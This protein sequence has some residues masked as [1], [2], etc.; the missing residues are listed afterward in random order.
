MNTKE[1]EKNFS[2]YDGISRML[3]EYSYDEILS[4]IAEI[5][6]TEPSAIGS[7]LVKGY[8]GGLEYQFV[9]K[10]TIQNIARYDMIYNM[11]S[12][13]KSKMVFYLLIKH[14]VFPDEA[15]LIKAAELSS[16]P[17]LE[18]DI[19]SFDDNTVF[20]EC[21]CGSGS[22][23]SEFIRKG[24]KY[25]KIFVYE[26]SKKKFEKCSKSLAKYDN[27]TVKC[28][29]A[30]ESETASSVSLDEDISQPVTYIK[31]DTAGSAIPTLI[32]AKRHIKNDKP[33][34]AVCTSHSLSELWEIPLFIKPITHGYVYKI[35]HYCN[36]SENRT[37]FYATSYDKA[38]VPEKKAVK[39]VIALPWREGWRNVE[40]TK[41]C[42][43]I[44]FLLYKNHGMDVT[45][46]GA[47]VEDYPYAETVVKGIKMEFL[48]K[49]T[50][51]EKISYIEKNA[52]DIDLFIVRGAYD[53]NALPAIKYKQ[54]NP[55]GKIYLGLDANSHWMDRIRW[56]RDVYIRFMESCDVIATSCRSLQRHLNEKWPWK[57]EYVPNGFY[58]YYNIKT[59]F[60]NSKKENTILTVARIGTEQKANN[61]MLE[62]F[63]KAA[64]RIPDWNM[65]L[66]GPIQK[67]FEAF[68]DN[69][70]HRY[71]A[72]KEK[73]VF[74]GPVND[75]KEL[76]ELYSKAKIFTL[77]STI[78]GG[79]PNVIAEAL[80][81]GCAI[82]VTKIDA[83]ED[84]TDC[85]RCG[86]AAEINDI[87]GIADMY[88]KLCT[89]PQLEA[90][91]SRA[92]EY[93]TE[94]YDMEKVV[95]RLE[96]SLF[97]GERL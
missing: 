63:A 65:K 87:S 14:R 80:S 43:L 81:A 7:M 93:Y 50:M 89:D 33:D 84:A 44:P 72:L 83:W 12:E 94:T 46:A 70:F 41:D 64:D 86:M 38:A 32:G 75:K 90:L 13:V 23:A 96:E 67:D 56:D 16:T 61:I 26:S 24:G 51:E 37:V 59:G 21:G 71:P 2:S 92:Y 9:L 31:I 78:E 73:V 85:G 36:N 88:V 97:G 62:A 17:F 68:T 69:F 6:G 35:R 3:K 8:D 74:T 49:G 55:K 19:L 54:L 25:D 48:E 18:D 91:E 28:Q 39:K 60:D 57:I 66:V 40:L 58:N 42:G 5:C 4:A 10:D 53:I 20:A 27:V 15:F 76:F 22:A 52:K 77:T 34:I 29:K 30:S 82:A 45:M 47:E 79:T 95:K 11:L 1:F